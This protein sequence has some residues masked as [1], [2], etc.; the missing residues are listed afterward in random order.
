MGGRA[1]HRAAP[2]VPS[3]RGTRPAPSA[4]AQPPLEPLEV[5]RASSGWR[6]VPWSGF[7][8]TPLQPNS[9][10]FAMPTT[11]AP[12]A[13]SRATATLSRGALKSAKSREPWVTRQ[14]A[15][16]MAS[17]TRIGTPASRGRSPP[18]RRRSTASAWRRLSA[19][20]VVTTA[21]RAGS[22]AAI[23]SKA[24]ATTSEGRASPRPTPAAIARAE[25]GPVLTRRGPGGGRRSSAAC[26]GSP[27]WRRRR[28]RRG[29]GRVRP[30]AGAAPERCRQR[31]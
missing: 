1:A 28:G 8:V 24:S 21:L 22:R 31:R 11:A 15:T 25:A 14:P 9:D 2:S 27:E 3:A 4:D 7:E 19:G 12:A 23:L 13:L 5:R 29:R 26:A 20:S 10:M 17:L 6:V 30:R 16:Q 18:A